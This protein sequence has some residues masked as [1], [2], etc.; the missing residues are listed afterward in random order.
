[1]VI[2]FVTATG[3]D[4]VIMTDILYDRVVRILRYFNLG[5]VNIEYT[6][7]AIVREVRWLQVCKT[8]IIYSSISNS[9]GPGWS[10]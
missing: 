9:K 1:M 3:N 2:Q 6:L 7:A 10:V 4:I 5:I 8:K